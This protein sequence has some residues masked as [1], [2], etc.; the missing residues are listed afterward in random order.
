MRLRSFRSAQSLSGSVT[1]VAS[2]YRATRTLASSAAPSRAK[3]SWGT[4]TVSPCW[5]FKR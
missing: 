4:A 2:T 5:G 1:P 3:T